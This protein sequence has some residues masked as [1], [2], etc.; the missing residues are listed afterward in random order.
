MPRR[1]YAVPR[2]GHVATKQSPACRKFLSSR[3]RG[4][5][6][7]VGGAR[8]CVHGLDVAIQAEPVLES[9]IGLDLEI[10]AE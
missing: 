9:P 7:S 6:E 3:R 10:Q 1:R 4:I 8:G 5:P 2:R